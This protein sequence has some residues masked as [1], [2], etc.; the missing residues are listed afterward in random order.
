MTAN[1]VNCIVC[2]GQECTRMAGVGANRYECARCGTFVL[3]TPVEATIEGLLAEKPLR[4]SLMSYAI[5]RTQRFG[6]DPEKITR[7]SLPT[8]WSDERLPTLQAQVDNFLLWI[9]DNQETSVSWAVGRPAAIAA[10]VGIPIS[11]EGDIAALNWLRGQIDFQNWYE[12]GG[13]WHSQLTFRLT[14]DG[15]QRYQQLKKASS[16]S[17]TA[18][19]ALKFGDPLLD[20]VVESCFKPAVKRTGFELRKLTDK[21]P[22][23]LIDNQIR[24]AILS[25]RFV[26]AD[27]SHANDGAYWEAGYAE[28]LGLPVIY[29]CEE[30]IWN[31]KKTHFDTNHMVTIIWNVANLDAAAENLTATIRATFR[32]EA[33]QSDD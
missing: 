13:D 26:I 12:Q 6:V 16:E 28:G 32:S 18:F 23:G 17:R 27:L 14:L 22:A 7:S 1:Y 10:Y 11:P 24:A 33:K 2:E 8:F 20:N 31:Q 9:G 21:Q 4:R 3:S 29:T 25:G 5:R 30:G 19:M 15:S